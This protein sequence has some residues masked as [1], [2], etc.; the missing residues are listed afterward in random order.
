MSDARVIILPAKGR[1]EALPDVTGQRFGRLVAVEEVRHPKSGHRASRCRCDCGN[2]VVIRISHLLNENNRSCGCLHRDSTRARA[3]KH[4]KCGSPEWKVWR[5]MRQR[6]TNPNRPSYSDYGGRGISV[7]P[8]W[9][10]FDQ[11]LADMGP[12][13]S[14]KHSIERKDVNGHYCRDNCYWATSKEQSRNTRRTRYLTFAGETLPLCEWAERN[15]LNQFTINY[16]LSHGWSV[17]KA[18]TTPSQR[19]PKTV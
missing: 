3:T 17:E 11:F 16:R 2:E 14:D 15:G 7:C 10:S 18:L 1:T 13:P 4:G 12:R 5:E 8:E 19:K 6:C 9:D